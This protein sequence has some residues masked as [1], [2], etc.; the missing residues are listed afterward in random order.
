MAR[1]Q[2]SAFRALHTRRAPWVSFSLWSSLGTQS[3]DLPFSSDT[4]DCRCCTKLPEA[5]AEEQAEGSTPASLS[6]SSSTSYGHRTSDKPNTTSDLPFGLLMAS[7]H[8]NVTCTPW[9]SLIMFWRPKTSSPS[10]FLA[11]RYKVPRPRPLGHLTLNC[12][13][14]HSLLFSILLSLRCSI[15]CTTQPCLAKAE[16]S[17]CSKAGVIP[18]VETSES[19]AML[20][21]TSS[22][23]PSGK[24]Y[25][26]SM[27][28]SFAHFFISLMSL[29]ELWSATSRTNVNTSMPSIM[30]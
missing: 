20:S 29:S 23:V 5:E 14:L 19:S 18:E 13:L 22:R 16:S 28:W 17:P 3:A 7:H 1:V 6:N 2:P 30:N 26:T 12:I 10:G 24:S 8:R 21:S 15:S 9:S 25:S 4:L 27:P 11:P